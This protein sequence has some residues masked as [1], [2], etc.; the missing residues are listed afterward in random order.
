LIT[1]NKLIFSSSDN[2]SPNLSFWTHDGQGFG[3][4]SAVAVQMMGEFA[5]FVSIVT[6]AS[7]S[8][9]R[10]QITPLEL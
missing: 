9:H 5:S 10:D 3:D 4:S 2:S 7:R 1:A 8:N 6:S